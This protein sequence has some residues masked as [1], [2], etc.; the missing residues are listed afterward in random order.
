MNTLQFSAIC[1]YWYIRTAAK[2]PA[3]IIM[4]LYMVFITHK[5]ASFTAWAFSL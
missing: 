5:L 1:L 3:Y 2:H 4:F